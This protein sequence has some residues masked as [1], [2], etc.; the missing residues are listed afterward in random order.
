MLV[1]IQKVNKEEIAVVTSLDIAET[2][3]KQHSHVL[4]DIEK[5]QCS[6]GFRQSNF[7]LSSYW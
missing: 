3:E 1:E 2:F 5:L 7:G 4:S 6:E